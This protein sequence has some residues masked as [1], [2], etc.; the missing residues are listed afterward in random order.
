[1]RIIKTH[2]L[3]VIIAK[4]LFISRIV[5]CIVVFVTLFNI[6]KRFSITCLSGSDRPD[7]TLRYNGDTNIVYETQTVHR[8]HL[9]E[10]LSYSITSQAFSIM[11]RL[12]PRRR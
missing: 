5:H 7:G 6:K 3:C 12:Q 8:I 4:S 1:M 10:S 11:W 2:F 9:G